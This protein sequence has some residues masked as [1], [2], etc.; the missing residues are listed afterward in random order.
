MLLAE[1]PLA[2]GRLVFC[3]IQGFNWLDKAH[4]GEKN[5]IDSKSTNLNVN[6]KKQTDKQKNSQKLQNNVWPII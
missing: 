2:L 3:S 1:V 4:T 6:L 5:L